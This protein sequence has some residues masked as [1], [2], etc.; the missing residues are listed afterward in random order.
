[1]RL[2]RSGFNP[3]GARLFSVRAHGMPG[4]HRAKFWQ[5]EV[6]E[7][8]KVDGTDEAAM[9]FKPDGVGTLIVCPTQ[10]ASSPESF[11]TQPFSG[12]LGGTVRTTQAGG[13]FR[14]TWA[15]TCRDQTLLAHYQ[16]ALKNADLELPEVDQIVQN[17][18]ETDHEEP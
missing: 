17:I 8:W 1:M 10:E 18:S 5:V 13:D 6:P 14:R 4:I 11:A 15:L 2:S 16:C 12:R 3:S 9:L 7:G